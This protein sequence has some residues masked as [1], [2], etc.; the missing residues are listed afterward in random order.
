MDTL[1]NMCTVE[2][3]LPTLSH[4]VCFYEMRHCNFPIFIPLWA[5]AGRKHES[6]S[7]DPIWKK[8]FYY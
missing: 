8:R 6:T 1:L 5:S 4:T 2:I 7:Q 3:V